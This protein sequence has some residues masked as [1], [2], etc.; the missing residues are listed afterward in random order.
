MAEKSKIADYLDG[1]GITLASIRDAVIRRDPDNAQT[2][3][4]L[5][6]EAKEWD[7]LKGFDTDEK[8]VSKELQPLLTEIASQVKR[9]GAYQLLGLTRA[10]T[11]DD[12]TTNHRKLSKQV[13]PDLNS[14]LRAI[15]EVVSK[16]LNP[17]KDTIA[18]EFAAQKA[19]REAPPPQYSGFGQG[20]T[21]QNGFGWGGFTPS[22]FDFSS[23]QSAPDFTTPHDNGPDSQIYFTDVR[24]VI[25]ATT[26]FL[27][28]TVYRVEGIQ[29]FR[30]GV[31]GVGE[32]SY[33]TL[34]NN[35]GLKSAII[36]ALTRAS[37]QMLS[38]GMV[39]QPT[40]KIAFGFTQTAGRIL[41]DTAQTLKA[42][43]EKPIGSPPPHSSGPQQ[44]TQPHPTA[45][46]ATAFD[47]WRLVED[48][49]RPQQ[50]R[51]EHFKPNTAPDRTADPLRAIR[52]MFERFAWRQ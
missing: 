14:N 9:I 43:Q 21:G 38:R 11:E 29:P 49:L 45:R 34:P 50:P 22:D 1:R 16:E 5:I 18:A 51:S 28:V 35:G 24:P 4:A 47:F 20:N 3:N 32:F 40:D 15:A 23:G 13:H 27:G 36:D 48:I 31:T 7:D 41:L 10:S 46:P 19:A 2:L 33:E 39:F 12:L 37:R 44:R 17:A 26:Y 6:G 8:T 42:D 25:S 52:R 30:W